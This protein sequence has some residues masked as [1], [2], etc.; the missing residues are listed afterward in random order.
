MAYDAQDDG[1][2]GDAARAFED[3]R[4]A[5]SVMRR[6]IEALPRELAEILPPVPPDY[7]SDIGKVA[8][9]LET[10]E[11]R[12]AAIERHPALR[13]TPEQHRRSIATAGNDLMSEA[14]GRLDKAARDQA[15]AAGQLAGMIG[16][17]RGQNSQL[18]WV[19]GTAWAAVVA[20]LLV[21]PLIVSM[22]PFGLNG[23]VAAFIMQDTR[24][25]AGWDLLRAADPADENDALVGY[26]LVHV[27]KD[28][29]LACQAAARNADQNQ[30]CTI[31]V[32]PP[33]L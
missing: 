11:S 17:M 3:L 24:W 1:E 22:L 8:Q 32:K 28:V 15:Q 26:E 9:G 27:N 18:N 7:R 30:K 2:A 13:L 19:I 21:S 12:L 4:S 20:G 10:V 25:N 5:I 23:R 33:T 31:T 14:A 6:S 29:L 16:T